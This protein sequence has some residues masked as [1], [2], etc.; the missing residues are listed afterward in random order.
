MEIVHNNYHKIHLSMILFVITCMLP[1]V[2]GQ[3]KPSRG[4]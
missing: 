2:V 1:N 4:E 3:L